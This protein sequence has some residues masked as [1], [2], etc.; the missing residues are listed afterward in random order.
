[1]PLQLPGFRIPGVVM[2]RR[3]LKTQKEN[4]VWAHLLKVQAMGGTY[5]CTVGLDGE[6]VFA[7]FAK[8]NEVVVYGGFEFFNGA[9]KFKADLALTPAEDAKVNPHYYKS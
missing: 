4:K 1:M 6:A 3:E 5:E 7:K 8:G 9:A 2:E